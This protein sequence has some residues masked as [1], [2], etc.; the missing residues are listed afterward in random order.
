MFQFKCEGRENSTSQLKDHQ[1]GRIPSYSV[2]NQLFFSIQAFNLDKTHTHWRRKRQPTPVLL[3]GKSHG[4]RSLVGYSPW[5]HKE[6]DT[7]EWLYLHTL[8]RTICFSHS[9]DSNVNL[10]QTHLHRHILNNVW[11]CF[12]AKWT[13]KIKHRR[14]KL[15]IFHKARENDPVTSLQSNWKTWEQELRK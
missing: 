4:Q 2:E 8:G 1:A 15:R 12:P 11:H 6:L 10:I 9:T 13:H 7:T 5:R 14:W 3:P